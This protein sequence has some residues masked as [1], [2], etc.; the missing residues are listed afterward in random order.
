MDE[1]APNTYDALRTKIVAEYDGL[2]NRL[3]QVARFALDHPNEIAL[4]T[5]AVISGRAD[6]QPSTLIRFAKALGYGGFSEMQRLFRGYL[7]EG[8]PTYRDRIAALRGQLGGKP[9]DNALFLLDAFVQANIAALEHLRDETAVEDLAR[10]I[11]LLQDAGRIFLL[12]QRRAFPLA[13]YM[14]YSLRQLGNEAHLL[15]DV[16][17]M[18]GEEAGQIRAGDVLLAISF[19]RYTPR[20][21]EVAERTRSNGTPVIA[22]TDS[23]LSPLAAHGTVCFYVEDAAVQDFRSLNASMCLVQTLVVGLGARRQQRPRRDRKK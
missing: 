15:D 2:S 16:G 4:E 22:I 8:R 5:T 7:T 14:F 6:V 13:A 12:G 20:V 1:V 3:Q 23:E 18:L 10:A 21:V 17:G 9:E 19:M 11:D